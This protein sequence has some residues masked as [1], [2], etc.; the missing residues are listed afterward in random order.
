[1]NRMNPDTSQNYPNHKH[2]CP[3]ALQ[4]NC[5]R[6]THSQSTTPLAD[7]EKDT[8]S[9]DRH[10]SMSVEKLPCPMMRRRENWRMA[11]LFHWRQAAQCRALANSTLGRCLC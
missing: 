6:L 8:N 7:F 1:M 2:R 9:T 4:E 3:P 11:R 5:Y 10:R